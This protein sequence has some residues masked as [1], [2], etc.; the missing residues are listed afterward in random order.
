MAADT[1]VGTGTKITF[2]TDYFLRPETI[3]LNGPTRE[4]VDTTH[5][6]IAGATATATVGR[7]KIPAR[8]YDPGT[9]D[10]TW[11]FDEESAPPITSTAEAVTI[12]FPS[13]N[14]YSCLGFFTDFSL[15]VDE[16]KTMA[17]GTITFTG[18]WTF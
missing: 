4:A 2:S 11:Q 7:T 17:S 14:T 16:G 12:T 10:V 5:L 15:S 6:R 1:D 3:Q 13:T 18:N 8:T 9:M